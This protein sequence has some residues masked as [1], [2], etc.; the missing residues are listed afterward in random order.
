MED[1]P[2]FVGTHPR[3][4]RAPRNEL[5]GVRNFDEQ[6]VAGLVSAS[7]VDEPKA[8]EIEKAEPEGL[9]ASDRLAHGPAELHAV[10]EA[11]QGVVLDLELDALVVMLL[12]ETIGKKRRDDV[13]VREVVLSVGVVGRRPSARATRTSRSSCL[14]PSQSGNR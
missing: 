9:P 10:D 8:V 6:L 2:E 11:R 7:F 1:E 13:D 4:G 5:D 12:P 14:D 3:Y